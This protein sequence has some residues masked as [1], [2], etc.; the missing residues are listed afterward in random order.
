MTQ[1]R[2]GSTPRDAIVVGVFP[3]ERI[4]ATLYLRDAGESA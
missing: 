3:A 1:R 2:R 4:G